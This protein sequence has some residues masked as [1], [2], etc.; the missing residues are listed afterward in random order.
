[1]SI[2]AWIW[3]RSDLC[4]ALLILKFSVLSV[5]GLNSVLFTCNVNAFHPSLVGEIKKRCKAAFILAL[6]FSMADYCNPKK[7]TSL[8]AS[9]YY[10]T[11]IP[12]TLKY[13]SKSPTLP[14]YTVLLIL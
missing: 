12:Y 5:D 1:M 11:M 13:H 14:K 8:L 10:F 6:V 9:I 7:P 2:L 3:I 4:C